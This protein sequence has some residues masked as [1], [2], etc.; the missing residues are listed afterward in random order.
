M[1]SEKISDETLSDSDGTLPPKTTRTASGGGQ[2]EGVG[3][4]GVEE[5]EITEMTEQ[6]QMSRVEQDL[7]DVLFHFDQMECTLT[8]IP[9]EHDQSVT[10]ES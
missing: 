8:T 6:G 4:N 10:A 7:Q 2:I 1:K 9:Q 3:R 5:S